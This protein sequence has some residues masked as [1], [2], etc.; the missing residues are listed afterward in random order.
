MSNNVHTRFSNRR[1]E[2]DELVA[3]LLSIGVARRALELDV[4]IG[5]EWVALAQGM[6]IGFENVAGWQGGRIMWIGRSA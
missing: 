1:R 6:T 4:I 3:A 2:Q 5:F